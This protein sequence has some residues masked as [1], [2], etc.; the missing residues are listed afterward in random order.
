MYALAREACGCIMIMIVRECAVERQRG[1]RLDKQSLF[2][3]HLKLQVELANYRPSLFHSAS[4]CCSEIDPFKW[5]VRAEM[6]ESSLRG[7]EES[8]VRNLEP[9]PSVAKGSSDV[10]GRGAA[11]G[12]PGKRGQG[13]LRRG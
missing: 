5:G 11:G 7:V 8:G 1:R 2:L 3:I 10:L 9:S 6:D 12:K 13:I 4:S